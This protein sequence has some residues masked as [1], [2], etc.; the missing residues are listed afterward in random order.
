MLA[1]LLP[2]GGEPLTFG[3]A[4][5]EEG[6]ALSDCAVRVGSLEE[7]ASKLSLEQEEG[8]ACVKVLGQARVWHAGRGSRRSVW[9]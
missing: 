5:C 4:V 8:A 2:Q 1:K 9:L 6:M 7:V 3:T